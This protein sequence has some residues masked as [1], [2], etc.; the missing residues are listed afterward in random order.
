MSRALY[1]I[2]N[3]DISSIDFGTVTILP[4]EELVIFNRIKDYSQNSCDILREKTEFGLIELIRFDETLMSIQE[5]QN[6][7]TLF[8]NNFRNINN[9]DLSNKETQRDFYKKSLIQLNNEIYLENNNL[10]DE[11]LTL[12]LMSYCNNG[13]LFAAEEELNNMIPNTTWN[14]VLIDKY[15]SILSA[16]K[17]D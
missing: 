2:R 13:L 9:I 6:S 1:K 11:I 12:N 7:I 8:E 17:I 14:T 10:S 15:K 4:L 5:G 16:I 3:I